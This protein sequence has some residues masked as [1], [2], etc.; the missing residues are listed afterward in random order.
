M[1]HGSGVPWMPMPNAERPIQRVP[2]GLPAPG[3]TG[4][5]PAAHAESG[6][7]QVGSTCLETILSWPGGVGYAVWPTATRYWRS[8]LVPLKRVSA[9]RL[10][11]ITT[12]IPTDVTCAGTT[13]AGRA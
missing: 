9:N 3:S 13:L 1:V 10:R 2:S 4:P 7:Y 8:A 5:R 6:G 11:S 12:D